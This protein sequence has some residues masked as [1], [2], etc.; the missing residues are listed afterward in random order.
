MWDQYG[1]HQQAVG[2]VDQ[3]TTLWMGDLEPWMD[4]NYIRQLWMSLGE[5]VNVK[6]IR[7]KITGGNAGYCFVDFMNNGAAV[8]QLNSVNGTLI[9]GTTRIF[10]L[11]WASGGGSDDRGPEYS[12][13]VGDLGPEVTDFM[14]LSTFQGRYM[15]CKSAKVV[16]DPSTGMSRGYGFV[17]FADELE[18]QRAM[19]EMQGQYCGSRP[20]R[21]SPATP[22]NRPVGAEPRMA[23]PMQMQQQAYY[24]TPPQQPQVQPVQPYNQFNDPTN[25]TVFVGG[26]NTQITDEELR[27]FFAPF[28]E[29]IYTKIP[30]GKQCG[31]VQFVHRQSAELAIQQMNGFMIGGSRVRLSWGR[32]QAAAKGDYRPQVGPYGQPMGMPASPYGAPVAPYGGAAPHVMGGP[33]GSASQLTE[34]PLQPIPVERSNENYV[35]QQEELLERTDLDNGWRQQV[36][37]Q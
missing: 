30:P 9:P 25:T 11:N 8:K 34:D 24:Q 36:Y 37:A 10:K 15:T 28:G 16:T 12:I 4:E 2:Y 29:I 35:S 18:Q 20:M 1:G 13:F 26:L 21:I 27:S 3:K 5:T 17:R 14:L 33:T 19:A 23:Q 31:F 32:S 6:M 22:K 7:D